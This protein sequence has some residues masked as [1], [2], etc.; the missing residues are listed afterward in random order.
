MLETNL[1]IAQ[2][3]ELYPITKIAEKLKI[4]EDFLI[5]CG[6]YI[7]KVHINQLSE[8][9]NKKEGK[10]ILVS[11]ITP[12]KTGE[13]KTTC[14]I[15]IAQALAKIGKKAMIC[16]RQP[17]SGPIF[18]IKGGACGG[19]YSQ[20]LPMEDINLHFTGD[21]HA[22]TMANALASAVIDN[23]LI[24]KNPLNLG[25]G[26]ITWKRCVDMNERSLRNILVGCDET[27][28][29]KP[30]YL[31]KDSYEITTASEIMA[32]LSLSSDYKELKKNLGN[33]IA[34]FTSDDE[35]VRIS[36]L[37]IEGAMTAILKNAI[38]PNL[39]Q[40]VEHVP[41]FVHGGAFG[42][43][44]HGCNTLI[45]TKM[46][47]KLADYVIT[48]A[49]F[50]ADLGAEKFFDIK[51]RKGNLKPNA[52]VIVATIK[53]LKMHGNGDGLKAVEKGFENLE[54]QI[55]NIRM[56]GLEPVVAINK[57]PD[58]KKEEIRNIID[59]CGKL[60]VKAF[61][62]DVWSKGGL[63]ATELAEEIVKL[64][65]KGSSKFKFLYE[66]NL[67]IKEKMRI[68]AVKMYGAKNVKYAEEAEKNLKIIEKNRLD[69]LPLC[70]AKTQYSLSD[71]PK[72]LGRPED[73]GITVTN[74]KVSAGAGFIVV[75]LGEVMTMPGLPKEPNA[76]KIDIDEKGRIRGL[77]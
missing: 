25:F 30:S 8:F 23:S 10:L 46:A 58:D 42:N 77:F 16:I 21:I 50:G 5:P 76:L 6:K 62:I 20:V 2:K 34:G 7:A 33:M 55:E 15:G 32:V 71:N 27:P 70:I 39:V 63:G 56:F 72:L 3:S 13:G 60:N 57:F 18:G 69:R 37:K 64:T 74:M 19:G 53:A 9:E 65:E 22:V 1:S 41:A 61:A 59:N 75:Y 67:P 40:S 52:V 24:N 68:I 31:R 47:L 54:K 4:T 48:E 14:T 36:D 73:F 26:K 43:V 51:C 44:A 11:A 66:A 49:G 12:T 29:G 17:S 45:A 28:N 35:P 38:H